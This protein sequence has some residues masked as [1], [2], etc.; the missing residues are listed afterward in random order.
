MVLVVS[1]GRSDFKTFAAAA[2]TSRLFVYAVQTGA[3]R[4]EPKDPER[5]HRK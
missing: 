2:E 5:K 4:L 1:V 3:Q